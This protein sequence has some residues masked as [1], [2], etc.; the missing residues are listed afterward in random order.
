MHCPTVAA[1]CEAV[2]INTGG[3]VLGGDRWRVAFKAAREASVTLTTQSAERVYRAEAEAAEIDVA[4]SLAPK[5]FVGWLPR[6]TILFD[7]AGLRRRFEIDMAADAGLLALESYVFGRLAM[8]ETQVTGHLHDRWRVR[9]D[10]KLVF[11]DDFRLDGEMTKILD[12]PACGK[13]ARATATLLYVAN[14]CEAKLAAL[15]AKVSE[16]LCDFGASTW[17]GILVARVLSPSPEL[18]RFPILSMVETLRG[19]VPRMWQ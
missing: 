5:S 13:G 2:L 6:E 19:S 4:L 18:L 9:R 8:G 16:S 7:G 12:E 15:R 1:G 3:G 11:A 10:G 14:D 17:N